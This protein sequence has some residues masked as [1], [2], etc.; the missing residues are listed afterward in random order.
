MTTI[1]FS[2]QIDAFAKKTRT[3]L[4]EAHRGVVLK[5]FGSIIEDTP[6]GDPKVD[7]F[8][9]RA[10]GNWQ[11][12]VGQAAWSE[13]GSL[14]VQTS[15]DSLN[16][17]TGKAGDTVWL[18]NGLPYM[19]KLEYGGYGEGPRTINGYSRQA[20]AGMVRTNVARIDAIVKEVAAELPK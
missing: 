20:P 15:L 5:L 13:S 4:D 14:D 2:A 10:R 16:A 1:S 6:V 17:N 3:T 12:N 19:L 11:T 7:K 8:S 9:G 18:S